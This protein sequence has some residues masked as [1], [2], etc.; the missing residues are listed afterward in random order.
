MGGSLGPAPETTAAAAALKESRVSD[1]DLVAPSLPRVASLQTHAR[2]D[3]DWMLGV[4][5]GIKT[6]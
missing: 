6:Q 3:L 2:R 1:C 4:A 5:G